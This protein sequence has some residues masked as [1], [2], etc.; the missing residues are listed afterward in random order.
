MNKESLF[1]SRNS[2][3]IKTFLLIALFLVGI[4]FFGFIFSA[5]TGNSNYLIIAVVAS[6]GMNFIAFFFSKKIA[7]TT[8]HALPADEN[9]YQELHQ[10]VENLSQKAHIPKPDVYVINDPGPNA[11]ATGRNEHNAAVAVTTGLLAMMNKNELEGV[12]AHELTHIKHK[13]ILIMTVV[14]VLAGALSML[15]NLVMQRSLFGGDNR[16]NAIFTT[17]T[18]V[19]AAIVLPLAATIVQLSIS[20]KREFAADAGGA[21]V[22]GYPEGLAS[23]L[24]KISGYT[25]PLQHATPAT[26]HLYISDPFGGKSRQTF[27]QKL[28][29][30]HPPVEE[31]IKALVGDNLVI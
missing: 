1:T 21:L 31:R 30:T 16:D 20:R 11:F 23:A 28:F 27:F 8:S 6:L 13:D 12:I 19:I 24:Q 29:M 22:T 18:A 25:Q 5:L 26:A 10:I 3:N 4:V 2:N 14:V 15:A 7:L 17:I 9:K